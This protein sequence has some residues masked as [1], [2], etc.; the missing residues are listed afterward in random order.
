MTMLQGLMTHTGAQRL[1]RQDLLALTTPDATDTHKPVPHSQ[2]VQGLI[3]T[4]DMRRLQV[5]RDEYAVSADGMRIF[6]FLEISVEEEGLRFAIG[7]RNSHD[8]S[9]SMGLT[10]GYR[11]F[12]CDNLAFH[13]DFTPVTRKH[14]KHFDAL[15]VID[16][17]VGKMQRHF[18]PMKRQIDAWKGFDLP[19]LRAKEV[20][21]G[22]FIEGNLD[23]PKHLAK[24]VHHE[25]FEPTIEE[26]KPRTMWALSNA[27]TSA[28]K[29]LDPVPQMQATARLAPFL[30]TVH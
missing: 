4:L 14:T 7:C 22:A 18:E 13:G 25:Y 15:E 27:F 19:D 23:V 26:F 11:V 20:I 30:A 6:G 28:F 3:E 12:V 24:V 2:I 9:F 21:Y 16:V 29:K 1:G 10:V 8:K 5:V 17:A